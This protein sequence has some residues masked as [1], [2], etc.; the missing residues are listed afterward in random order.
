MRKGTTMSR[1]EVGERIASGGNASVWAAR[2]RRLGR[3]VAVKRLH[4]HLRD[5]AKARARFAQEATAASRVRHPNVVTVLDAGEDDSGP[6]LVMELVRG[7]TLREILVR[8]G[9]LGADRAVAIAS[10]LAGALAA[11]HRAG[12]THRDIKP[13]NVMLDDG[14][15]V[16]LTDFGIASSGREDTRVTTE[17]AV[18]GT[19]DYMAPERAI[20]QPGGPAADVYS[21]GLVVYEMLTGR[22]PFRG[23]NP[24]AVALAHLSEPPPPPSNYA[25]VPP[26]LEALVLRALAK[27]PGRRFP[28]AVEFLAALEAATGAAASSTAELPAVRISWRRARRLAH[29]FTRER[30]S[31][32]AAAAYA[33]AGSMSTYLALLLVG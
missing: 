24:V 18:V 13:E 22:T 27:E 5:D 17:G 2:D 1:Y 26:A 29:R 8:E 25:D 19:V 23:G 33:V 15:R 7:G 14:N 11:A 12:V 3:E 6:Y 32:A 20:G 4:P 30:T 9:A 21:L 16:V 28:S 10:Q 31:R